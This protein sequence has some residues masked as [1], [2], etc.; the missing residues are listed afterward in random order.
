MWDL[1]NSAI[2]IIFRAISIYVFIFLLFRFMGKKQL[3]EMSS[4]DF[5]LL[6]IISESVSNALSGGD[7]SVSAGFISAFTLLGLGYL[8]DALAFRSKKLEKILEGEAKIII[9][10]GK[11]V[12]KVQHRE[13][14][15]FA[16]IMETLH[17]EGLEKLEQVKYGIL[18]TNGNISII[19][20]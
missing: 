19:E 16:E 1:Q 7:D 5:V 17:K 8:L 10:H 11:I 13:Q 6:L 18:E 20:K 15:T 9:N 12:E 3:G 4:F 2:E 14:I